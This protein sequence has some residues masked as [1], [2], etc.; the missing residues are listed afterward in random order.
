MKFTG[1][2]QTDRIILQ[3]L[4]DNDLT[5][6]CKSNTYL[7]KICHDDIFWMNRTIQQIGDIVPKNTIQGPYIKKY[8]IQHK[9]M[10]NNI[11]WKEYYIWLQGLRL[12]LFNAFMHLLFNSDREDIRYIIIDEIN[13][14]S[15][16][17]PK[18]IRPPQIPGMIPTIYKDDFFK[19]KPKYN[20]YLFGDK[21]EILS[22]NGAIFRRLEQIKPNSPDLDLFENNMDIILESIKA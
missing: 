16:N 18:K 6:V 19:L 1:N 14:K 10:K 5:S 13:K 11:T 7:N 21:R 8:Y 4:S 12:N 17:F 20:E 15:K 3:M 9:M 2:P 22:T